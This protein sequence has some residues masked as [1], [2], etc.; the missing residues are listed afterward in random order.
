M[1]YGPWF[2]IFYKPGVS[3]LNCG[4]T[5]G[6]ICRFLDMEK[7][8]IMAIMWYHAIKPIIKEN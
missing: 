4:V 3:F 5:D 2:V 7:I 8:D 6:W 1:Q